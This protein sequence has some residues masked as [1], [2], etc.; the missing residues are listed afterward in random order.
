MALEPYF[1]T[2]Q[3]MMLNGSTYEDISST[4]VSMGLENSGSVSNIKH[5]CKKFGLRKK[6]MVSNAQ[7]EA[8]VVKAV[9]ETGP[10]Y[11]RRMMA[12]YLASKGVHASQQRVAA[13]LR[14]SQL[15]NHE[16]RSQGLRN[17]N[18][19]PYHAAYMGHKM[20]I[21]Q[22][23]KMIMFGVTYVMAIDGYSGKVVGHSI[24]PIKNNLTIYDEVYKRVCATTFTTEL[25]WL[26]CSGETKRGPKSSTH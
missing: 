10:T 25:N 17:L 16:A 5:F 2:I 15:S 7:L 1:D 23:E 3:N 9:Q 22:N 6:G 13:A 20:H 19:L 8:A 11:G 26:L 4:L 14:V 24:M 12:G 21:D 18:P